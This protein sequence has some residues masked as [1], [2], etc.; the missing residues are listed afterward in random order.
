M[1]RFFIW[2]PTS[3]Q[4]AAL[5]AL[6]VRSDYYVGLKHLSNSGDT[7]YRAILHTAPIPT[8]PMGAYY[9]WANASE[10]GF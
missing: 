6:T 5:A 9:C 7:I 8:L 4:H 1:N 10:L 3:A 2:A